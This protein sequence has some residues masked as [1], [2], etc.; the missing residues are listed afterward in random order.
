MVSLWNLC[1]KKEASFSRQ[2]MT[3]GVDPSETINLLLAMMM[4]FTRLKAIC[5][6]VDWLTRTIA[7][8][9]A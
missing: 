7:G 5:L 1:F 9:I 2:E 4:T 3:V 6:V 8:T